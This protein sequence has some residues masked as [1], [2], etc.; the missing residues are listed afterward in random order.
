MQSETFTVAPNGP[1]VPHA[2]SS[3]P[4][5]DTAPKSGSK[6]STPDQPATGTA[7]V[8]PD[9]HLDGMESGGKGGSTKA[10]SLPGGPQGN[11]AAHAAAS[12]LANTAEYI[13]NND[14]ASMMADAKRLIKDN[15]G[16]A[17]LGA[18]IIGFAV[19]KIWSRD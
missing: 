18:A 11:R 10:R 6:M 14:A 16:F 4:I 19:A 15:P 17:L 3:E 8:Y 7:G 13:R 5:L 1:T 12:T 2:E 9:G